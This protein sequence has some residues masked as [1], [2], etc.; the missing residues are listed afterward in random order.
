MPRSSLSALLPLLLLAGS[1]GSLR[2]H[3]DLPGEADPHAPDLRRVALET[4]APQVSITECNGRFGVTPEHPTATY[5]YC[6]TE[7][8]PFV[9][10]RWRGT[11]DRTFMKGG[12]GMGPPGGRGGPPGPGGPRRGPP[13]RGRPPG[14]F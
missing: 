6:V 12:P 5:Y 13:G 1:A 2:A 14:P 4:P 8:F 3:P 11:P 10:R 9:A 7:E